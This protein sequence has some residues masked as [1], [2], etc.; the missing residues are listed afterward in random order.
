[1]IMALSC[2]FLNIIKKKALVLIRVFLLLDVTSLALCMFLI[3]KYISL[4]A[5][6]MQGINP[7]SPFTLFHMVYRVRVQSLT[8]W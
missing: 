6:Y 7:I 8:S 2:F 4:C 3:Y 5:L 1:M